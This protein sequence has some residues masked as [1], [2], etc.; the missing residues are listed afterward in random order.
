MINFIF[1]E[2]PEVAI[3]C[4]PPGAPALYS[5]EAAADLT[6]VHP[7]MLL[8]YCQLGLLSVDRP[9]P[10]E[11][12]VLDDN[13]LSEVRRIEHYRRQNGINLQALPLICELWRE[14]DQL[15]NELR[16]SQ[17]RNATPKRRSQ[18]NA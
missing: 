1:Y 18:W 9:R 10:G 14:I 5:L 7:G 15:R 3:V 4:L 6:G 17:A 2:N 11:D 13:A 12:P 8:H 16:Q